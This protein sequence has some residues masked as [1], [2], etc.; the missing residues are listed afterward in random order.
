M[1][2][3]QQLPLLPCAL[4]QAMQARWLQTVTAAEQAD[5]RAV[6]FFDRYNKLLQSS[7]YVTRRQ[8]LRVGG[9]ATWNVM[10]A[11]CR[12]PAAASRH[13]LQVLCMDLHGCLC[14]THV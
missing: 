3:V 7:N 10:H 13:C 1:D 8:S 2:M 14:W 9:H 6:Q 4:P 5:P 11:C 12:D